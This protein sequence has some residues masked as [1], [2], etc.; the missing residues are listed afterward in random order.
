[1]DVDLCV[2][3]YIKKKYGYQNMIDVQFFMENMK[4]LFC[5]C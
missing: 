5:L 2:R 1:M 4:F 3:D